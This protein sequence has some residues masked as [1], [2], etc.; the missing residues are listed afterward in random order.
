MIAPTCVSNAGKGRATFCTH[1]YDYMPT[2][3]VIPTYLSISCLFPADRATCYAVFRQRFP[4]FL[5]CCLIA[6]ST[7]VCQPTADV[8]AAEGNN[9][10]DDNVDIVAFDDNEVDTTNNASNAYDD[11]ND[12]D[13]AISDAAAV[14]ATDNANNVYD[15]YDDDN[16]E[17]VASDAATLDAADD[18]DIAYDDDN[19]DVA[20]QQCR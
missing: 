17:V 1:D 2:P 13:F 9:Y 11:D 6:A 7:F 18:A 8:D 4:L 19:A 12:V 20:R 15:G 10:D 16:V 3:T 14:Y 5:F